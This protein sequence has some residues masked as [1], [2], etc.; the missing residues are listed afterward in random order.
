MTIA[1]ISLSCILKNTFF[2]EHLQWLLLIFVTYLLLN[3][4]RKSNAR[5]VSNNSQNYVREKNQSILS[6]DEKITTV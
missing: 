2:L 6:D 4:F 3:A 1:K 5:R